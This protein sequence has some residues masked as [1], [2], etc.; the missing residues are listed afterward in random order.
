MTTEKAGSKEKALMLMAVIILVFVYGAIILKFIAKFFY[1]NETNIDFVLFMIEYNNLLYYFVCGGLTLAAS[2]FVYKASKNA[3][4]VSRL[5]VIVLAIAAFGNM[6]IDFTQAYG[7]FRKMDFLKGSERHILQELVVQ[8]NLPIGY[9]EDVPD[10]LRICLDKEF[11][12][13][14][15]KILFERFLIK[16]KNREKEEEKARSLREKEEMELSDNYNQLL[17]KTK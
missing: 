12:G 14:I 2:L 10:E 9:I 7:F 6:T 8:N 11:K 4:N 16:E 15:C 1:E 3:Y 13:E 5:S 17:Q